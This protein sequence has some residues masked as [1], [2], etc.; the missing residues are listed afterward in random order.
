MVDVTLD[1][2]DSEILGRLC[3]GDADVESLAADASLDPEYLRDRLPELADNGLVRRVD[4][5]VY[6]VTDSGRRAVAGSPAGTLDD[7]IDTPPEVEAAIEPFDLRPDR[8][9]AV[10]NAFAF[11]GYW[12]DATAMEIVDGVYS[13]NPAG[14]TSPTG[15]WT[16]LVRERLADLPLVDPPDDRG[17]PDDPGTAGSTG[18]PWRYAG[19]PGVEGSTEDG[20]DGP[21]RGVTGGTSVRYTIER[22]ALDDDERAAV[23]AAFAFLAR[24]GEATA[25]E[26]GDEVYPDHGAGYDSADEWW[27]DFVRGAFER[28]P[29]VELLD[30]DRETWRYSQ[31]DRGPMST[32]PGAEVPDG[33]LGPTDEREE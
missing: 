10:R 30:D 11:L 2:R 1:D 32:D 26:I 3:R 27:T 17:P 21:D 8:E 15:W 22:A 12:G 23:R 6:A 14:F 29:G 28:L 19:T 7:R 13:E 20:R 16:E 4:G 9:E 25:A 31:D 5:D 33:P 18:E 24:E